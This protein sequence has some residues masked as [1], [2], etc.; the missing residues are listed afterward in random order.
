MRRSGSF[1]E[2]WTMPHWCDYRDFAESLKW[3]AEQDNR[4]IEE[5]LCSQRT[6]GFHHPVLPGSS[7]AGTSG[8][9]RADCG[10]LI[11]TMKAPSQRQRF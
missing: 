7:V 10:T 2:V 9:I 11:S 8:D 5:F 3:L 6:T 1:R 4:K